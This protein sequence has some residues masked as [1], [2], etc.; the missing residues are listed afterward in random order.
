LP[1]CCQIEIVQQSM[2]KMPENAVLRPVDK[3]R[4]YANNAR[5]HSTEQ[6]EQLASSMLEFGFTQPVLITGDGDIIAGHGR[7]MAAKSLGLTEVPVIVLDHLTPDQR[8]AYV[9]ADNQLALN[10]GW[11][12]DILAA[13]LAALEHADFNL[14]LIGFTP[15]Q[16]E[17][18]LGVEAAAASL[19]A[20]AA[21]GKTSLSQMTFTVTD[22]QKGDIERAMELAKS[23]GDFVDTG[24]ENSNG[25]ALARVAEMF[26]GAQSDVDG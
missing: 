14:D 5:T 17:K 19:P 1:P 2:V 9:I 25:N 24:N 16:M 15:Q 23:F 10:A 22:E 6:I 18:M 20:L 21:G 26:L 7:V 3:L 4:P 13:E 12:N 11:D 8:R